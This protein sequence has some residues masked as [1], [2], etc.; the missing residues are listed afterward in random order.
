MGADSNVEIQSLATSSGAINSVSATGSVAVA[1]SIDTEGSY[2]AIEAAL[3][4]IASAIEANGGG[5][6]LVANI[7]S[8]ISMRELL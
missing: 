6:D 2:V 1:G 5:I 4:I 8:K 3:E 7:V